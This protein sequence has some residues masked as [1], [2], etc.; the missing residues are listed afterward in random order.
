MVTELF[1]SKIRHKSCEWNRS[2]EKLSEMENY[3]LMEALKAFSSPDFPSFS[4]EPEDC[5]CLRGVVGGRWVVERWVS[6]LSKGSENKTGNHPVVL[7]RGRYKCLEFRGGEFTCYVHVCAQVRACTHKH[8]HIHDR[9]QQRECLACLNK[10]RHEDYE[11]PLPSR[12]CYEE[13]S[14]NRLNTCWDGS[15]TL[16]WI[17]TQVLC[18]S[19]CCWCLW[20]YD[21]G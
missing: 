15:V 20:L 16:V 12:G 4:Y 7:A 8:K 14:L 10:Q 13:R 17:G 5:V 3:L 19:K 6:P 2:T 18:R 1:V 21:Y 11:P 9:T